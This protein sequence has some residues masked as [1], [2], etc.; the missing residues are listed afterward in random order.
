MKEMLMTPNDAAA[1]TGISVHT[2]QAWCRDKTNG[3]P[4]F[5]VGNGY[6][7]VRKEFDE[8]LS[9]AAKGRVEL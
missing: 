5:R 7:I 1:L 2:I 9:E 6:K 8:W 3:F 4:S